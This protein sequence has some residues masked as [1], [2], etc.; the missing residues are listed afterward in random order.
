[1]KSFLKEYREESVFIQNKKNIYLTYWVV[2]IVFV[3]CLNIFA[4]D[5]IKTIDGKTI[6][7][8]IVKEDKKGVYVDIE[9][10]T[11]LLERKGIKSIQIIEKWDIDE[12]VKI[13]P[14]SKPAKSAKKVL[15]KN[16][17]IKKDTVY[18]P[19]KEGNWWKYKVL[20]VSESLNKNKKSANK[21]EYKL[22][23]RI[24]NI[25]ES[26]YFGQYRWHLKPVYVF[27]M[28]R[29]GEKKVLKKIL[30]MGSLINDL[31]KSFLVMRTTE[32]ID[33]FP[34]FQ[35]W[36]PLNPFLKY[37][38]RWVDMGQENGVKIKSDNQIKGIESLQTDYGSYD[39]CLY[40]ERLDEIENQ[41]LKTRT[42]MWFSPKIGLV[43]LVQET[44][45]PESNKSMNEK[46]CVLK[47]YELV[48]YG[49]N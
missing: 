6:I 40:I 47:S 2:T 1:L 13:L 19:L 30:F 8:K 35:R 9:G 26:T 27:E 14:G 3:H 22:E 37:C 38:R 32:S 39:D 42:R 23:W 29:S 41:V 25:L 31:D 16:K 4:D 20:Y 49:V 17:K 28:K 34:F 21:K 45:F 48:E 24:S 7:G 44:V 11:I 33:D 43:K 10:D 46:S 15:T 36:V 18:F 12:N 5:I